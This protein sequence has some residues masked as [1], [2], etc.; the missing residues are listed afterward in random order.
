MPTCPLCLWRLPACCV[1]QMHLK[2]L[3]TEL[4]HSPLA[5]TEDASPLVLALALGWVQLELACAS[6]S[7]RLL[8][9]AMQP[10]LV[11]LV[12][13]LSELLFLLL[14]PLH[15]PVGRDVCAMAT[16]LCRHYL[17]RVVLPLL[18]P[19]LASRPVLE[20]EERLPCP[21]RGAFACR[22]DWNRAPLSDVWSGEGLRRSLAYTHYM[23]D[24]FAPCWPRVRLVGRLHPACETFLGQVQDLEASGWQFCGRGSVVPHLGRVIS[25]TRFARDSLPLADWPDKYDRFPRARQA[26]VAAVLDDFEVLHQVRTAFLRSLAQHHSAILTVALTCGSALQA[27]REPLMAAHDLV[28]CTTAR[29]LILG[30]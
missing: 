3:V 27:C 30:Y 14:W 19:P 5:H 18:P 6:D 25:I 11:G 1:V 28:F 10:C 13:E 8:S 29:Q 9:A 17:I 16:T 26:A 23:D 12:A 22:I 20:L 21:V 15:S 4:S 7:S 24:C 2:S